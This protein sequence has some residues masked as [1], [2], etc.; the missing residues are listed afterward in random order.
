MIK[1]MLSDEIYSSKVLGKLVEGTPAFVANL[2][3]FKNLLKPKENIVSLK[4]QKK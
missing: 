4:Y 3:R 1:V 2:N